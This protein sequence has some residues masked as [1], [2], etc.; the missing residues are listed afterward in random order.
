MSLHLVPTG[1]NAPEEVNVIIEI[2]MGG[3]PIKYEIDKES[4][5][6]FVDRILGTSMRYPCNYGYIPHTLCGDGDPADVLVFM[7]RP[8]M[9]GSVVKCRPIGV[10][11]M[12]DESGEDAK[13]I[14]V[15]VSKI[16]TYFDDV[17]SIDDIPKIKL[18]QIAH[19]FE[20]YKDLE[21][22]K[23]VKVEGW[24]GV[25]AAKQEIVDSI[26]NYKAE[27]DQPRF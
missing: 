1:K 27:P 3:E 20:H 11:K 19:F 2:P 6:I 23:W 8:L 13:L 16:S 7:N 22:G 26:E 15:P 5:A 10:L 25:D 9:P 12:T 24:A 21:E 4:G 17:K 14:A 18:D